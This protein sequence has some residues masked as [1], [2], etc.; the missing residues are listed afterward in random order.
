MSKRQLYSAM[1]SYKAH[2]RKSVV[3]CDKAM[4]IIKACEAGTPLRFK[5]KVSRREGK[6]DKYIKGNKEA[7]SY[8]NKRYNGADILLIREDARQL[9]MQCHTRVCPP[10]PLL[11]KM[12]VKSV[13]IQ[14]I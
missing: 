13:F 7:A 5:G 11:K 12:N 3:I 2:R 8:N 4:R 1:L 14:L 6:K 9:H 10:P